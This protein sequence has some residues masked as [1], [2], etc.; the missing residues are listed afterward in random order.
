MSHKNAEEKR[1]YRNAYYAKRTQD[2]EYRKSLN[3]SRNRHR[4]VCEQ[5]KTE[6]MGRKGKRFCGVSC[7]VKWQ[8]S[9]G[10]KPGGTPYSTGRVVRPGKAPSGQRKSLVTKAGYV[11]AW[12]P[13][14]PKASSNKGYIQEHRIV[15]EAFLG[16]VLEQWEHVHHKNGIKA[17][18]RLENLAIVTHATHRG[19]VICPHCQK[20]FEMH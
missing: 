12:A 19:T 5:C 20:E 11:L 14:H 6:F 16:R 3:K 17:D 13:D 8:W 1:L 15:V 4:I 2:P 18:N 9:N 7:A 10:E